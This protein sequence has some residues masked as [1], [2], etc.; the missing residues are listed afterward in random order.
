MRTAFVA[1]LVALSLRFSA[2]AV[3]QQKDFDAELERAK[4]LYYSADFQ[5]AV[6]LLM[7]L[8]SAI[9]T[10]TDRKNELRD[11]TLFLA[12][13]YLGLGRLDEAQSTFVEVCTL[14]PEYKP[15]P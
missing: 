11:G 14:D 5:E 6:D 2:F 8:N 9:R 12:L 7:V 10:E 4:S 1:S 13:S 15:E 3:T